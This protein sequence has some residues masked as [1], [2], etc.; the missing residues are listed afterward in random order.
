[1]RKVFFSAVSIGLL[2]L[3]FAGCTGQPKTS[4]EPTP[5]VGVTVPLGAQAG[6]QASGRQII[7]EA[8]RG[9][10]N[11]HAGALPFYRGR[12][13]LNWA[14]INDTRQIGVTV[15]YVNEGIDTGDIILQRKVTVTDKDTYA[16]LLARAITLCADV[17]VESLDRLARGDVQAIAQATIHPVGTY[18]GR[19]RP[20]DEWIDWNWPS[21]RIF[22][23]VR[24]IAPPGPGAQTLRGDEV[25]AVLAAQEIAQAVDYIAT[26]GEIV[27][28]SARGAIVKTGDSTLL[29]TQVRSTSGVPLRIGTRLGLDALT[30]LARLQLRIVELEQA[31][32]R[33]EDRRGAAAG[34]ARGEP[35]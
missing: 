11:C 14:L 32:R 30:T 8:P 16:S 9:V 18:F 4:A 12:N 31:V 13:I 19:R 28:Q 26:P 10:I 21:R 23:F 20:G 25:V 24:A 34:T 22:N 2:V 29:L 1:M 7:A 27:G 35:T 5:T 33:L 15:H 17:L 3:L 6:G